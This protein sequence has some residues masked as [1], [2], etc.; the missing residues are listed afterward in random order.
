[1]RYLAACVVSN[2][3]RSKLGHSLAQNAMKGKLDM[4]SSDSFCLNAMYLMH[5]LCV[6]FLNLSDPK[7]LWKKVDPTYLPSGVR[8]D[9]T[10]ETPICSSKDH[11]VPLGM[12]KEFGTISEFYFME[13]Q[14]IHYGLMHTIRKYQDVRKML[15]RLKEDKEV[16]G[17]NPEIVAKI[18][19]E[20]N[21]LRPYRIAYELAL[22][23][24][25]LAKLLEKFFTVHMR[26]MR[27]WGEY[28]PK[29]H[30][31]GRPAPVL[32]CYLPEN[33]L[34]DFIDSISEIMKI[35]SREHKAFMTETVVQIYEFCLIILRTESQAITNPYTKAKALEL[36]TL[37]VYADRKKELTMELSKSDIIQQYLM[38]TTL[39][40]YVDIEFAGQ[41]MFFTKFQYRHDCSM[42]FQRFWAHERYRHATR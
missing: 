15:D 25:Q 20:I 22:C 16:H 9:I 27:V 5:E 34:T 12:P 1:M 23:D 2:T 42:L 32:F 4:I 18:E 31:F 30:R 36:M 26:L 38:E 21:H 39:Q 40:F 28:E 17:A 7:E 6:P 13:L 41:S 24:N 8:I 14:M 19:K 35:N 3:P 33:F 37:F 11:K 10:D 29:H